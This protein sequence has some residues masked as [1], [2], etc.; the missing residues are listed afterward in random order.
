VAPRACP[1]AWAGWQ[2]QE[3]ESERHERSPLALTRSERRI[4]SGGEQRHPRREL[5]VPSNGQTPFV[6]AFIALREV[7]EQVSNCDQGQLLSRVR[8]SRSVEDLDGMVESSDTRRQPQLQWCILRG[9][10]VQDDGLMERQTPVSPGRQPGRFEGTYPGADLLGEQARLVPFLV[11]M[12][13]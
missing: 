9:F 13:R 4:E 10:R 6:F 8:T 7:R 1:R 12:S 2:R 5:Q 11:G 3:S